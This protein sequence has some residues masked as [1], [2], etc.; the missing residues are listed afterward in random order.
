MLGDFFQLRD[1]VVL[2]AIK[3]LISFF[4][5]SVGG[6]IYIGWR[7][8]TLSMFCWFDNLQLSGF[9]ERI[10]SVCARY[11]VSDWVKYSLPDGLWLFS[12]LLLIDTIWNEKETL[13][14]KIYLWILPVIAISTEILQIFAIVPGVFDFSDLLCYLGAVVVFLLIK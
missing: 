6:L 9:I 1:R 7:S 8:K 3:I 10:R 12:Y 14:Y 11:D 5:L 13:S 2:K 4:S